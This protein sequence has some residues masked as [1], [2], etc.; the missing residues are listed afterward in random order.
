MPAKRELR[1][2]LGA[3]QRIASGAGGPWVDLQGEIWN[4]P[5]AEKGRVFPENKRP[6]IVWL[7]SGAPVVVEERE[8][9]GHWLKTRAQRGDFYLTAPGP[10]FEIK[11][12][13]DGTQ[14]YAIIWIAVGND[15]MQ[16]AMVDVFG[17]DANSVHLRDVSG[18]Q[19]PFMA[20]LMEKLQPELYLGREASRLLVLGIAESL[21]VHL[22]RNYSVV[23]ESVREAKRGRGLPGFKL[24]KITDFMVAH[25]DDGFSLSKLAAE[26]DMSEFHFSRMFK[27]TTGKS[28]SQYFISLKMEKAQRLLRETRTGIMEIALDLGYTSPSRFAQVF[29]REMGSSPVEYRRTL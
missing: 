27:R 7:L 18:F 11:T 1:R 15:L 17:E 12:T 5:L 28:P 2:E 24:R 21:A 23:S 25:L 10:P 6:E 19:D 20:A 13:G 14:Q 3:R 8:L 26:A 29:R 22:A 16:R 4:L 9:G